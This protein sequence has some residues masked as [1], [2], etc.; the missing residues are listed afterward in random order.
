MIFQC[1]DLKRNSVV[2]L[3]LRI[4]HEKFLRFQTVCDERV[5]S[6]AVGVAKVGAPV[7]R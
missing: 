4:F 6:C 1:K 3:L 2:S 7:L 5:K